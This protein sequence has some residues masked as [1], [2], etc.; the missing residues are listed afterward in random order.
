MRRTVQLNQLFAEE[1]KQK[2]I[3]CLPV[4]KKPSI[5]TRINL[6]NHQVR[7]V[8]II[9]EKSLSE[10]LRKYGHPSD[11]ILYKGQHEYGGIR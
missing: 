11:K 2:S 6:L 10:K 7:I 3:L 4:T 8:K 5:L 9:T 1:N